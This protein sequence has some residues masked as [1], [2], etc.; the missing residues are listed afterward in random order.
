[1]IKNEPFMKSLKCRL[2]ENEKAE[3]GRLV[4]E[5]VS[6]KEAVEYEK[7]ATASQ[8]GGKLKDIW[9]DIIEKSRTHR[10]GFEYR[11]VEC[12]TEFSWTTGVAKVIRSDTYE[13]VSSR[14]IT[15]DERQIHIDEEI[16]TAQEAEA[17]SKPD[18]GS[19]ESSGED[20][21]D[22]GGDPI[23]S[24]DPDSQADIVDWMTADKEL[25][26]EILKRDDKELHILLK[27]VMK[28][29]PTLKTIKQFSDAESEE[30]WA[31]ATELDAGQEITLTKPAF[32]GS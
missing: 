22:G 20:I 23:G 26:S 29:A 10:E 17:G 9:K 7:A 12:F 8:Y 31:W 19:E 1:M 3:I 6:K 2:T 21:P 18:E 13:M 5:L 28:K 16:N 4:V 14:T 30:C 27:L 25:K 11:E 32:L 15:D 24:G